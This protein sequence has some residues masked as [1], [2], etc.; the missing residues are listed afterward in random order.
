MRGFVFAIVY[1]I[2]FSTLLA[3]VPTGLQ[4]TGST[5]SDLVAVNPSITTDF[6]DGKTWTKSNLSGSPLLLEYSLGGK[7]WRFTYYATLFLLAEKKYLWFLWLGHTDSVTFVSDSG[8]D[9]GL[10]LTLT[11]IN[12]DSTGGV[13]RYTITNVLSGDAAGGFIAH[14]NTTTYD[15]STHAWDNDALYM[16]HG[17]GFTN[18]AT[19]D[20]GALLVSLLF[21]QIPEVPVLVSILLATPIW[22]CVIYVLW[23]VIKEMIPF[24]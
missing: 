15:N 1:I 17:I 4:G 18:T 19:N 9:R 22:A 3:S 24:L 12:D 20:I 21:L 7:D 6:S 14:W 10:S 8:T 16:I 2:L 13:A 11:N 5:P 23:Y